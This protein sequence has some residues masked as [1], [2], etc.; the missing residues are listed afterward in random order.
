MAN[1]V[2]PHYSEAELK[3]ILFRQPYLDFPT[4]APGRDEV[5]DDG[6]VGHL[7]RERQG[8]DSALGAA[9]QEGPDR[10]G[11]QDLHRYLSAKMKR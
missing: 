1:K 7:H 8:V 4:V 5:M 6:R 11:R 9:H 2:K 10:Q 3:W